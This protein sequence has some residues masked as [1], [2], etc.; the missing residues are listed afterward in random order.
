MT[1]GGSQSFL[2][3][4]R[5]S[6][7]LNLSRSVIGVL[8][9]PLKIEFRRANI[10]MTREFSYFMQGRPVADGVIDSRF[11]QRMDPHSGPC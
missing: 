7:D 10:A 9:T 8:V 11:S 1:G 6:L 2:M 4:R 5:C 3:R